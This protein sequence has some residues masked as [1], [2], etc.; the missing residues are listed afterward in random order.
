[1]WKGLLNNETDAAIASTI[2]GQAKEVETSPRGLFYPATPVADTAGWERLRKLGPYFAPHKA[3]CGV[4]LSPQNPTELPSYAYPIFMAYASQPADLVYGV[5]R[6]MI[7]DY[8]AYKDN[9]PGAAGL[10][11]KRQNLAWV[12]PY[13]EGSVRA[14]KEAGAWKPEHEAHNQKLVKRQ[15]TLGSAWAAFLKTN[16]PDDKSAFAKAWMAA[17]KAALGAAGMDAV[18]E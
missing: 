13:H 2:T 5:A 8:D 14:L 15:E 6:A 17:R 7:V 3:T 9:A 16:P 18:F 4:G 10:E 11:V 12:L 1:M